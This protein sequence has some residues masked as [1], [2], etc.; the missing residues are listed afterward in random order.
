MRYVDPT[1]AQAIALVQR[2]LSGPFSM[3][4]LLRFR[5]VADYSAHPALAPAAPISGAEAYERYVEH[6]RP[7]LE[8]TGGEISWMGRGGPLF[9]GP[10]AER[11]DLAMLITQN[12]LEDFFAF[13]T[14]EAYL[15]GV[16]HR[17]AAVEDVRML[18][19]DLR[20]PAISP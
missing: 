13:A 19:L 1:D 20:R 9:V 17:D 12:S 4:N 7:F 15:A 14:N 5:D 18:A 3:L 16:G 10:V 11:W 6:T 2:E 8:A